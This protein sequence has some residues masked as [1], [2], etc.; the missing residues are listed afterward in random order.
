LAFDKLA[1][2]RLRLDRLALDEPMDFALMHHTRPNLSA[3]PLLSI[4]AFT[5]LA[6]S[7]LMMIAERAGLS[8]VWVERMVYGVIALTLATAALASSTTQENRFFGTQTLVS[9]LIG[10]GVLGCVI[11]GV[12]TVLMKQ[13]TAAEWLAVIVG[14]VIGVTSLH[15]V[16][17]L[18]PKTNQHANN[19]SY[20]ETLSPLPGA[21]SGIKNMKITRGVLLALLGF[22]LA[23]PSLA[24]VLETLRER[25]ELSTFASPAFVLAFP[26]IALLAGGLR[27]GI[28]FA[29]TLVLF[30][31]TG[32]VAMVGTGFVTLGDLPLP[33]WSETG[34]LSAIAEGRTRW[35]IE[36]PLFFEQWP[37]FSQIF[38]GQAL[39]NLALSAVVAAAVGYS[40]TP[41]IPVRR[42]SLTLVTVSVMCLMP[43]ALVVIGGYAIEAAGL[44]FVG[45][46]IVK[47]PASLL[48]AARLGMVTICGASPVTPETMR[49]ACG[50]LPRDTAVLGWEQLK[51]SQA[52]LRS[53]LPV[54]LGYPT[55]MIVMGYCFTIAMALSCLTAGLWMIGKGF[56]QDILARHQDAPG[57]ASFRL[58]LTRLAICL[59][60][61]ALLVISG[62]NFA[63]A[64][65]DAALMT[66]M[67]ALAF[68]ALE[69]NFQR[70]LQR[71]NKEHIQVDEKPK[72]QLRRKTAD[73]LSIAESL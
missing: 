62:L 24:A 26:I 2:D 56:G 31:L 67:L 73:E 42:R 60:G 7:G 58:A 12:T 63:I 23:I 22:S 70:K 61:G 25:P 47:P 50:V 3:V 30:A 20:Q 36:T 37:Q 45:A 49:V 4:L 39:R 13:S 8:T 27:A 11:F 68:L 64:S 55:V 43:L 57:L 28:T 5:V 9:A 16:L 65:S 40:L 72:K 29:A 10:A 44:Q 1:F 48:E 51:I 38:Y 18:L 69:A 15:V 32:L 59:A 66:A 6:I 35:E 53:G 41:A 21:R 33:G 19:T 52:F 17:R 46:A 54:A 34:T 14:N 71:Y